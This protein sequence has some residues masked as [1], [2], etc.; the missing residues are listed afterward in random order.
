MENT[1][2]ILTIVTPVQE[3]D[4][5]EHGIRKVGFAMVKKSVERLPF[6]SESK[7]KVHTSPLVLE[8]A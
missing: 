1:L 6:K 8:E 5:L 3:G 4:R 7:T 2:T